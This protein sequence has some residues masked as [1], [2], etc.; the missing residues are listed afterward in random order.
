MANSFV[1]SRQ[2]C[3]KVNLGIFYQ[4]LDALAQSGVNTFQVFG[5]GSHVACQKMQE[6]PQHRVILGL[7]GCPRQYHAA[8]RL[9]E[10]ANFVA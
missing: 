9:N 5:V 6:L 7:A 8:V 10:V 3:I 2:G 1:F 4:R